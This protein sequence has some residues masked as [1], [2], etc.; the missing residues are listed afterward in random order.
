VW[1]TVWPFA[2]PPPSLWAITTEQNDPT[3]F[4]GRVADSA[5]AQALAETTQTLVCVLDRRGR[6]LFFNDACERTTGFT[7]HEVLGRDARDFVIPPEERPAFGDVLAYVWSTGLSSPVV[8]HWLTKEGGRRLIAWSNKPVRDDKGAVEYLVTSG[9]DLTE[10][11]GEAANG[12]ALSGDRDAKLAEIGRLAQEQRALRRVATL[13]ASEASPEQVFAA[14]SEECARVLEVTTSA[15]LRYEGNDTATVVGRHTR[16]GIGAF[17]LGSRVEA[18][19]TTTIGRILES[20]KPERIDD[21]STLPGET[22]EMMQR[23]GY[24]STVSAPIVVAGLLWGAVTVASTELLPADSESRLG[25]FCELV[26]L[27]VASAQAR[28]DLRRSRARL[29]RA[30]DDQR[31]KFERNL[32]DGAQQRL[33]AL[34]LTLRVA[35]A[36]L[37]IAPQKAD[38]LLAEATA[39]LDDALGELR[40]LA[41]G[42]HPVL[43]TDHGLRPALARLTERTSV[44]VELDIPERRFP[45]EV[46]ATAYYIASEALVNITKHAEAST[47]R[48]VVTTD[49]DALRIEITDD[50]KGGADPALGTGILGLRDRAEAAGGSLVVISRPGIGTV[51]TGVLPL[52][53]TEA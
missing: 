37:A 5:F 43:L 7:R 48:V 31:R 47:A 10:H 9:L 53:P 29:V 21:Y 33:V 18:A 49:G 20:G 35:R 15:V 22:A 17:P 11:D 40:E 52:R 27:A 23:V 46:E 34:A 8:G 28:E 19:Q 50:G 24:R 14:V 36:K 44:P 38:E 25:A 12:D 1:T 51:V 45:E 13:V 41:R 4:E 42:L 26:S 3:V 39:E 32:H 2:A 30:G 16:D 6:I